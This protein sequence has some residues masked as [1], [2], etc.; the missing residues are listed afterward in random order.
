MLCW[1]LLNS[2]IHSPLQL[3]FNYDLIILF[4]IHNVATTNMTFFSLICFFP[5]NFSS[6]DYQQRMKKALIGSICQFL[7]HEHIYCG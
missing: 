5:I 7:W 1:F 2:Y 4:A 3:P 6:L